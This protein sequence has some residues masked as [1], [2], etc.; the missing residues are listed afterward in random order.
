[1]KR[2]LKELGTRDDTRRIMTWTNKRISHLIIM[3]LGL[4]NTDKGDSWLDHTLFHHQCLVE[5]GLAHSCI[6][7]IA[8]FVLNNWS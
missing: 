1:M 8:V 2:I 7:C 6:S 4:T 3:I 5:T